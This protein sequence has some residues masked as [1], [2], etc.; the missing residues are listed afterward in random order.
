MDS[1]SE[2]LISAKGLLVVEL[3]ETLSVE[4]GIPSITTKGNELS[5]NELKPRTR[6]TGGLFNKPLGCVMFTPA[7]WPV[8]PCEKLCTG[9][10]A[11]A[12][13]LMVEAAPVNSTRFLVP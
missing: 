5:D 12:A 1:I 10:S 11:I 8:K 7:A 9:R 6:I 13:A 3:A 2:G 4:I